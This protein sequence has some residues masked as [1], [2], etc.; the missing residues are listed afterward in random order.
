[1]LN[2]QTKCFHM[3]FILLK[4]IT[5]MQ[6]EEKKINDFLSKEDFTVR[7]VRFILVGCGGAGKTT[8]LKRLQNAKFKDLKNIETTELVDVH[9]NIFDVLENENTIQG[10]IVFHFFRDFLT[11]HC[12]IRSKQAEIR[13]LTLDLNEIEKRDRE[14]ESKCID[15][16]QKYK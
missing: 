4:G 6:V 2:K 14:Y 15:T 13:H 9:V 5:K 3:E 7:H 8:L 16:I 11:D 1:M 10:N 12:P